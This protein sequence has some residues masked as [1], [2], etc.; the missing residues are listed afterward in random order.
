MSIGIAVAP[1]LIIFGGDGGCGGN[2]RPNRLVAFPFSG[3]HLPRD[4]SPRGRGWG[5]L[6]VICARRAHCIVN[7][8]KP[9]FAGL[10]LLQSGYPPAPRQTPAGTPPRPGAGDR[11]GQ[12]ISQ[13]P[14]P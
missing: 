13:G 10:R 6:P 11:S 12:R 4:W 1:T 8:L 3:P 7:A 2:L 9:P 14:T 5:R